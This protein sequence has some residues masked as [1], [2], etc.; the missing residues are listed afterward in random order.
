MH[1]LLNKKWTVVS[2]AEYVPYQHQYIPCLH[3]FSIIYV[4]R[5]AYNKEILILYIFGG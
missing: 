2:I 5:I 1:L 3:E 4:Y